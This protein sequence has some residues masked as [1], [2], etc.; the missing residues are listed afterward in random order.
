MG[1][2]AA[3]ANETC[4]NRLDQITVGCAPDGEGKPGEAHE[5]ADR[6]GNR[7]EHQEQTLHRATIRPGQT[8]SFDQ[9]HDSR[10]RASEVRDVGLPTL[11]ATGWP[12]SGDSPRQEVARSPEFRLGERLE[13]DVGRSRLISTALANHDHRLRVGADVLRSP[14]SWRAPP[15]LASR[16]GVPDGRRG[17]TFLPADVGIGETRLAEARRPPRLHVRAHVRPRGLRGDLGHLGRGWDL[18]TERPPAMTRSVQRA[19]DNATAIR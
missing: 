14:R 17:P 9:L 18:L 8:G 19:S 11:A 16:C 15:C 12:F 6:P 13:H 1:R 4:Q 2:K 5:D 3:H 10:W 7:F